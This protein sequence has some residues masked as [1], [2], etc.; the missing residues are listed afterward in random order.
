MRIEMRLRHRTEREAYLEKR[1]YTLK[2]APVLDDEQHLI[3]SVMV[4][5]GTLW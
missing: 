3:G 4:L 2:L 1:E 5:C